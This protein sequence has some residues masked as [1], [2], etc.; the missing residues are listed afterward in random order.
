MQQGF[1]KVHPAEKLVGAFVTFALHF[2]VI[3]LSLKAPWKALSSFKTL[4]WE[5]EQG[6]IIFLPGY[7]L[8]T[9]PTFEWFEE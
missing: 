9:D 3:M 7:L 5:H 1:L 2:F 6:E 8:V 4:S